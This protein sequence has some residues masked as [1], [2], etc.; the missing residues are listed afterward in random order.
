M[1]TVTRIQALGFDAS[2]SGF[3]FIYGCSSHDR[4][5]VYSASTWPKFWQLPT[6]FH[7]NVATIASS[8]SICV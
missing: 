3:W 1:T 7:F 5:E 8:I 4:Y 6:W 2:K